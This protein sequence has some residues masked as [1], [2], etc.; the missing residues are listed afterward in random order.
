MIMCVLL[1]YPVSIRIYYQ[2]GGLFLVQNVNPFWKIVFQ[3]WK[4][5]CHTQKASCNQALL[6]SV[7]WY[8]SQISK[9]NL[10]Y[11]D[12][13]NS[14][15][16][17][18]A[19][20]VDSDGVIYDYKNLKLNYNLN[21][22]ILNYYTVKGLVKK[23]IDRYRRGD[24]FRTKRPYIPFHINILFDVSKES[25]SRKFYLELNKTE[26]DVPLCEFK[27]N[28]KFDYL[29][30]K[31]HWKILYKI[32]FQS[33]TEN[34]FVWFQYRILYMILGT[35]EYLNKLKISNSNLCGLCGNQSESIMH[36]FSDCIESNEL[37]INVKNWI[38]NSISYVLNLNRIT[39]ILGYI[40][41][42]E[43]FWP[44]NF[45]LLIVRNYI[46][47]CSRH[48][49]HLNIYNLQ[50]IVKDKYLEQESLSKLN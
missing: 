27:W 17:T 9:T 40:T 21:I 45:L 39:K 24:D 46:F 47:T 23:F 25:C 48:K 29:L 19:D 41:Y 5:Y 2:Q 11:P 15:I 37:W 32:C 13:F 35:N 14:G 8:N 42:D 7:L 4:L 43:N 44:L 38:K 30:H 3:Y 16:H 1:C 6:S 34:S 18:I 20:V 10:F 36:L 28:N 50:M 33:L 31:H 26:S 12:W 49:R 22:N